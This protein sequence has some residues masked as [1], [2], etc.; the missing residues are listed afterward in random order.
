MR[1]TVVISTCN[2]CRDLERTLA[3]LAASCVSDSIKWDVLVIDNNSTDRTDAVVAEYARTFP[4]R[5]RYLFE[6]I[7]GKSWSL[8]RA[9]RE[10]FSDVIA[11]TDD[12]V[13]V[14]PSWLENI[15]AALRDGSYAGTAGRTLP[16]A[17]FHPPRWLAIDGPYALA[18]LALFDRGLA[19]MELRESPYG[20]NM[21][22]RREVFTR[23]G[24]FRTDL[25]P[26]Y[27]ADGPQKGEDSEFGERLLAAGERLLYEPSAVLY[28][29][30]PPHRLKKKYFLSWS[31]DKARSDLRSGAMPAS[32]GW[33]IG[34]VPACLFRRLAR[35]IVQWMLSLEPS[36]RFSCK[37]K[38][39][40][41]AGAIQACW[42]HHHPA[43]RNL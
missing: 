36:R 6:P 20:N 41:V 22:Y 39:W 1:V 8:N 37:Q 25:G 9:I 18:P 15:S 5:F 33:R 35:W 38:F 10:V 24:G 16:P 7:Q 21:A 11:F 17:G 30:I 2:R 29:A 14:E 12:D 27:G 4:G 26:R 43:R 34:G 13:T 32:S 23:H 40:G 28:H 3:S 42:Y 31:W 19:P